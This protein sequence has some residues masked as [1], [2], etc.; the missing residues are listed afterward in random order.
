ML[1][2]LATAG[3]P[4]AVDDEAEDHEISV[5]V[6]ARRAKVGGDARERVGRK[7]GGKSGSAQL[8][9]KASGMLFFGR[10]SLVR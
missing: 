4:A 3:C 10:D 7:E 9:M 8:Q 1:T 5:D 6:R 2:C